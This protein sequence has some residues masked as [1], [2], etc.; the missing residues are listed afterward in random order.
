MLRTFETFL[1]KKETV[2]TQYLPFYLKWVSDCYAFLNE[3]LDNRLASEERKQFLTHIAK[4]HEEWQVK[5]ADTALRLYDYFLSKAAP[6]KTDEPV[7][8]NER[9]QHVEEKMRDALRLRHR[10]L[11]TEKTYLI[12]LRN[13]R[14]FVGEKHPHQLEGRDLQDFLS[15]LAVEKKVSSSTQ[16]QA[17]NAIV[18]LYRHVLNKSIDQELS[19]V[20]AKQRRHLPVVLT[21]REIQNIFDHLSVT[22]KLMAMVIYGAGLRLHECLQLRIK[23]IDV[24]QNMV[25]VRSGKGDKDRRTVLPETLKDDLIRHLSEIRSVYDQDRKDGIEGVWLPGALE[26]KYPN[27]GKEWGWFWLFPSKSYSIDPRSN[28][29]RRHHVHP[30]LL[31]KAFK[32]AVGKAGITRQASVHTL[33][34]SFATHLLENGYDIRTIQELLGHQNLQST[35]IYTHVATK[36]VLGVRSPLDK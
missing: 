34:H 7:S 12:W 27:A 2:K 13:F 8:H 10:A 16:N 22:L 28:T 5:Q 23:D 15:H 21:L 18:F 4:R 30:A 26:K 24:E 1:S 3:P 31:Q 6:P 14:G 29:I 20:R 11:S 35:M 36:N 19:A 9:W 32:I 25:I 33:R 17:L